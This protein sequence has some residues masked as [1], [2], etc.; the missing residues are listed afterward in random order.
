MNITYETGLFNQYRHES[1]SRS[2]FITD[3]IEY[4]LMF[5]ASF[6]CFNFIYWKDVNYVNQSKNTG[7]YKLQ[8]LT[9]CFIQDFTLSTLKY[10]SSWTQNADLLH[11]INRNPQWCIRRNFSCKGFCHHLH[12]NSFK[13]HQ[14]GNIMLLCNSKCVIKCILHFGWRVLLNQPNLFLHWEQKW[15]QEIRI[16]LWI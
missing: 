8:I 10:P 3:I 2:N 15:H 6:P 13:T 9:F 14:K 12:S 4:I 11:E 5:F 16:D 1:K 7:N